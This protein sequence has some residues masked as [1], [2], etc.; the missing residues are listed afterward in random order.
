MIA[1]ETRRGGEKWHAELNDPFPDFHIRSWHM[2]GIRDFSPRFVLGGPLLRNRLFIN[3]ALQYN[4]QR[5]SVLTLPYP[6]TSRKKNGSI[7]LH[8]ST[9]FYPRNKSS[10][11]PFTSVP[12]TLIS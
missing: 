10:R 1:V 12:N 6:A 2:R 11:Q 4:F 3:T 8:S 9:W 7:L 5:D